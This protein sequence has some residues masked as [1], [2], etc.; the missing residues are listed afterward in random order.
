MY[1]VKY[2]GHVVLP[3]RL[4][5]SVQAIDSVRLVPFPTEKTNI[6][7]LQVNFNVSQHFAAQLAT[8]SW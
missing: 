4:A 5:A 7:Y 6:E 8:F 2:H 3:P 1:R